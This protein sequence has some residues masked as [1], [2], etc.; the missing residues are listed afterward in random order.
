MKQG[1]IVFA[2]NERGGFHWEAV[3][4]HAGLA[5]SIKGRSLY[6]VY[7]EQEVEFMRAHNCLRAR[8]HTK[9]AVN[10]PVVP[11][12]RSTCHDQP[13]G[14][15]AVRQTFGQQAQNLSTALG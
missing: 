15:L 6:A 11:L 9:N 14:N 8:A 7:F 2:P 3:R 4:R 12:D 10:L 13:L 5:V 1:E